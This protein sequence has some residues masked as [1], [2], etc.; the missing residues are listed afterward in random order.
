MTYNIDLMS[1]GQK[2]DFPIFSYYPH[3]YLDSAATTHKPTTVIKAVSDFYSRKHGTVRRGLYHLASEATQLYEEARKITSDFIGSSDV[4]QII[5]NSGTTEGINQVAFRYLLPRLHSNDEILLTS[6]EHHANFIPWQHVAE[7]SGAS[8]VIIDPDSNG[9][10]SLE[11][12]SQHLSER[13]KLLAI[14]H[15]SNVTGA[16]HS[17]AQICRLA[18]KY[19]AKVLVDGA[20]SAGHIHVNVQEIGCDF[21]AFSAH[22]LYGP[23]GTGILY[24]RESY[25]EDMLPF[26]YG[27]EMVMQVDHKTTTFK[28]APQ[29]F[30]GGTPNIAGAIGL[31]E[32]IKYISQISLEQIEKHENTLV[33]TCLEMMV[34]LQIKVVGQ[35]QN[36]SSIIS[37]L[38]DD[39]HPHDIATILDGENISIRAGHHC[40]QPLMRHWNIPATARVSFGWYNDENDIDRLEQGLKKVRK[41]LS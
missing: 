15:I 29:K 21:F 19:D 16:I 33:R 12:V 39:I 32:A 14:N 17:V 4:R 25:L 36:R 20:Q 38:V 28:S 7:Q 11:R 5:F 24:C 34:G 1:T 10:I 27:G 8:L 18:H 13:T 2:N 26:K 23:T 22:K 40:A 35:P 9:D 41:K 31:A 3:T 6:Q 37:F 30:E